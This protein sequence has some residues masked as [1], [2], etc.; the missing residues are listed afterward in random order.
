MTS[1][2]VVAGSA[3]AEVLGR[4]LPLA[5]VDTVAD[6]EAPLPPEAGAAIAL[7]LRSG[8]TVGTAQLD[9]LPRL[10]YLVRAG[11][12][13]D[14]LDL[15]ALARRGVTVYRNPLASADAV[16]EWVV[17]SA[18]A[19]AR[20][21]PLGHNGLVAGRHLKAVCL[22]RSLRDCRLAIWGAGPVGVASFRA[23][24]SMVRT[25]VF[26]DWPSVPRDL[27]TKPAMEL[28]GWADVHVVALPLRPTTRTLFNQRFLEGVAER[29]PMLICPGR[30]DT[31]QLPACLE[32][33]QTGRLSGLAVDGVEV[34]HLALFGGAGAPLNLLMTP[35]IGAQRV[36]VR[37]ALDAWVCETLRTVLSGATELRP[38]D[39]EEDA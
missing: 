19:L 38:A 26:A 37:Q 8:V 6:L 17:L 15:A 35:H 23:L 7:V 5:R 24:E 39:R 18:L 28:L 31:L 14:N 21:V 9:A 29:R 16:G 32:A 33:L 34:G 2:L 1:V 10:R 36:D 27:P 22:G 11:S 4:E 30:S 20:R 13:L 3:D 25:V 12:G